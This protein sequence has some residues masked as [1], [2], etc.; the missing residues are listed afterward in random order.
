MRIIKR[1]MYSMMYQGLAPV[2]G[3][4]IDREVDMFPKNRKNAPH[5]NI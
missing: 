2:G 5:G 4:V 3:M 1:N